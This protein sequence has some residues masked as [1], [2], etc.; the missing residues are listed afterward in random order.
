[1][2]PKFDKILGF[3]TEDVRAI[4]LYYKE[5]GMLPAENDVDGGDDNGNETVV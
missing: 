4:L 3:S 1:M 5:A 2:N